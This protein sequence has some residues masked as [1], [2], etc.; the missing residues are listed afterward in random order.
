MVDTIENRNAMAILKP[1]FQNVIETLE[2]EEKKLYEYLLLLSPHGFVKQRIIT[3]KAYFTKIYDNSDAAR[4]LPHLTLANFLL[5]NL[6][7]G[8]IIGALEILALRANKIKVV[9][10]NYNWFSHHTIYIGVKYKVD[11][12]QLVRKIKKV[13]KCNIKADNNFAPHFILNPHLTLCKRLNIEQYEKSRI[14]Y[15]EKSFHDEFTAHEMILLRR[16]ISEPGNYTKV[17]RFRFGGPESCDT[18]VQLKLF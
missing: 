11:I 10:E 15:T 1:P 6:G 2:A 9:L 4:S 5:S 3:E 13:I 18:T 12:K 7:E 8:E 14:E 16:P 17:A